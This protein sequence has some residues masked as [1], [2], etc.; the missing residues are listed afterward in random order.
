MA[1]TSLIQNPGTPTRSTPTNISPSI[2]SRANKP[3]FQLPVRLPTDAT[4]RLAH[5]NIV[6]P[7]TRNKF[8]KAANHSAPTQRVHFTSLRGAGVSEETQIRLKQ[9]YTRKELAGSGSMLRRLR[10]VGFSL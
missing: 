1:V 10:L 7:Q 5:I 2:S 6:T 4:L 3:I 8:W 9:S